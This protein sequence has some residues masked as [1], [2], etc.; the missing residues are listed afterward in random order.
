[1]AI[2]NRYEEITQQQK[3]VQNNGELQLAMVS[4]MEIN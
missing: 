4:F 1:M 3:E 2:T